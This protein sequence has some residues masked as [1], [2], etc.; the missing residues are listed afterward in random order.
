MRGQGDQGLARGI[1]PA[2]TAIARRH[3]IVRF[4]VDIHPMRDKCLS[5]MGFLSRRESTTKSL[6]VRPQWVSNHIERKKSSSIAGCLLLQFYEG[7]KTPPNTSHA[8]KVFATSDKIWYAR[9]L[10]A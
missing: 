3:V 5:L 6:A 10:K 7:W 2:R 4:M 9:S 1:A 8:S